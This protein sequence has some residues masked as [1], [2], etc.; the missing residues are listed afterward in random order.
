MR[1]LRQWEDTLR[2]K[3]AGG[4]VLLGQLPLGEPPYNDSHRDELGRLLATRFQTGRYV[5]DG[6]GRIEKE[7]PLSFALFLVLHG[8]YGYER[9]EYW[10]GPCEQLGIPYDGNN[11]SALGQTFRGILRRCHLPTFAH[12]KGLSNLVPILAHGGIPNYSLGDFFRLLESSVSDSLIQVDAETLIE[13]WSRDPEQSFFWIDKPV[14]RFVLHGGVVATE[15]VEQCVTLVTAHNNGSVAGLALPQRV[16]DAYEEWQ[17]REGSKR[18]TGPRI[19]LQRPVLFIDPYAE[20]VA[21]ELPSPFFPLGQGAHSLRWEVEAGKQAFEVAT[22]RRR[23]ADGYEYEALHDLPVPVASAYIV[24]LHT[25][26]EVLRSWTLP[27]LSSKQLLMFD[28]DTWAVLSADEYGRPGERWILY[29]R[30]GK[31]TVSGGQLTKQLPPQYG[32]WSQYRVEEW[33]IPGASTLT[34]SL[35]GQPPCTVKITDELSLRRPHFVGGKTPLSHHVNPRFPLYSGRPPGLRIA[36]AQ[37]PDH[38]QL[39]R[40]HISIRAEGDSRPAGPISRSLVE[41][42]NRLTYEEDGAVILDLGA[43]DLL[44]TRPMGKFEIHAQGPFGQSRRLGLRIVPGLRILGDSEL[45]L[46]RGRD[47]AKLQIICDRHSRVQLHTQEQEVQCDAPSVAPNYY[48]VRTP[49]SVHVLRFTVEEDGITVAFTIRLRRPRWAL[50][51][52]NSK[53]DLVWHSTPQRIFLDA[54]EDAYNTKLYVDLPPFTQDNQLYGGWRLVDA[55]DNIR[56]ERRPDVERSRR[57]YVIRLPELMAE[58]RRARTEDEVLRLQIWVQQEVNDYF[59]DTLYLLPTLKFQ[60]IS[61]DW[62]ETNGDVTLSLTWHVP[63]QGRNRVLFLWPADE[64]WIEQPREATI[65][66]ESANSCTLYIPKIAGVGD[67]NG[68]YLATIAMRSPWDSHIPE[69]PELNTPDLFLISPPGATKYYH[70]LT[71]TVRDDHATVEQSLILLHYYH[72]NGEIDEMHT[73]NGRLWKRAKGGNIALEQLVLWAELA[74][75]LGQTAYKLVQRYGMFAENTIAKLEGQ[76]VAA[77]WWQR[78]FA[79]LPVDLDDRQCDVYE[80]LLVLGFPQAQNKC[81]EGLCR[82]GRNAGVEQLLEDVETGRLLAREAVELLLP[83]WNKVS[84]YLVKKGTQDANSLLRLLGERLDESLTWLQS[85][86]FVKTDIGEGTVSSLTI[87]ESDQPVACCGLDD[88]VLAAI[89]GPLSRIPFTLHLSNRTVTLNV[90][91]AYQCSVC[92]QLFGFHNQAQDHIEEVHENEPF[93]RLAGENLTVS[94]Q[95][96]K[97]YSR[98]VEEEGPKREFASY[99]NH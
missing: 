38:I 77:Q 76:Q 64:P 70:S 41:L 83:A 42:S 4:N 94:V 40:W 55:D 88:P 24:T 78:Y 60:N 34:L 72:R 66:D 19:R 31:L 74:Q 7:T 33:I 89:N 80:L 43:P 50:G 99:R 68:E 14:E 2:R 36:F 63:V 45:Y 58:Y 81:I 3:V 18:T 96:L 22:D 59:V 75:T 56:I 79:H 37:K 23:V 9:G 12:I 15:F 11:T 6:L 53:A 49:A 86:Y 67:Y 28:P 29:P 25:P 65:P 47:D 48:T 27:G 73:L 62:K 84:P 52:E 30:E 71:E 46:E 69:R 92:G 54:L 51:E 85:G 61:S 82:R 5:H 93:T 39:G 91:K 17:D 16:I 44:G 95:W 1:S 8:I 32:D 26:Q 97:V 20:G 10:P 21:I 87:A 57:Q 90:S 35:P 98:K 13:E